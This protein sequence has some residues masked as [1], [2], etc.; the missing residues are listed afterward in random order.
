MSLGIRNLI[1]FLFLALFIITPA[2]ALNLGVHSDVGSVTKE[3]SAG[4]QTCY[5]G[6]TIVGQ[7]AILDSWDASGHDEKTIKSRVSSGSNAQE[8]SVEN[9]GPMSTSVTSVASS[10]AVISCLDGEMGGDTA[11]LKL[12]SESKGNDQY[13]TAGFSGE[14]SEDMKGLDASLTMVAADS[15]GI[16][17]DLSLLGV[18]GLGGGVQGDMSMELNGIYAQADGGLGSFGA[19]LSNVDKKAAGKV[20]KATIVKGKY[21][22]YDN[23]SAY[24]LLGYRW[25]KNPTIPLV[26]KNDAEFAQEGLSQVDAAQ[27]ISDAAE[28]WDA[29]VLKHEL[30]L[31][32]VSF[33]SNVAADVQDWKNVHAWIPIESNALAYSRTYTYRN[34]VPGTRYKMAAESDVCY[35]SNLGW[36]LARDQTACPNL[37]PYKDTNLGDGLTPTYYNL[38]TVATHE[39]GHTL[40]LGDTYL[41]SLYK[42]DLSQI[43][44]YYDSDHQINLG[45]GDVAGIKKLYAV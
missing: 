9:S 42:Y 7:E 27:A 36:T 39:L 16:G 32:S 19:A 24:V 12:A 18:D 3:I 41:H 22:Y 35:N 6:K 45:L 17:G 10:D 11:L 44:G 43:M 5:S 26:L 23:P 20:S 25:P 13:L 38:R 4:D 33:D 29:Q 15:S 37:Y 30:F 14:V 31:N 2:N 8:I 21:A 40:G 28:I 34:F 1:V